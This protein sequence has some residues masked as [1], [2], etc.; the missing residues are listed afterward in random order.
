[1]RTYLIA[2]TVLY[3]LSCVLPARAQEGP[4]RFDPVVY[5]DMFSM[6][7]RYSDSKFLSMK[8]TVASFENYMIDKA[9]II[10]FTLKQEDADSTGWKMWLDF[11]MDR[12]GSKRLIRMFA[13]K[14]AGENPVDAFKHELEWMRGVLKDKLGEVREEGADVFRCKYEGEPGYELSLRLTPPQHDG[15]RYLTITV[16]EA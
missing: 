11:E 14:P 12:L 10:A 5:M 9:D 1:M 2:G 3:L 13:Q 15:M 6:N 8:H 16:S 7:E 4:D